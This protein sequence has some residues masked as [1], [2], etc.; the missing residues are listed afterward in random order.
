[1]RTILSLL[2]LLWSLLAAAQDMNL[3]VAQPMT[4]VVYGDTRFTD[5]ADHMRRN[6]DVRQALVRQI[7]AEDP[8]FVAISGDIVLCGG[9]AD[10]RV[11]EE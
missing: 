10:W 11:Y 6:P 7:A 1:M 5:P 8:A 4:F 2:C 3:H 9:P